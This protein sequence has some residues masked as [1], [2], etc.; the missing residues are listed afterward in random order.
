MATLNWASK[1]KCPL[2]ASPFEASP[3][4][5]RSQRQLP[6][7]PANTCAYDATARGFIIR[8]VTGETRLML[9]FRLMTAVVSGILLSTVALA[10]EGD[11]NG[12]A[13]DRRE[14]AAKTSPAAS[15]SDTGAP[16]RAPAGVTHEYHR[17]AAPP[18]APPAPEGG[19]GV[20][21]SK[22]NITNN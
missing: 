6:S 8:D 20:V 14:E 4:Q 9:K 19:Q 12:P 5:A 3:H 21:K 16:S 7:R 22:S 17:E 10:E 11:G 18:P 13:A 1:L 15:P 2:P